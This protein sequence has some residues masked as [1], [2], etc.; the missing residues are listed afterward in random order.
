MIHSRG[1]INVVKF[2]RM[3]QVV[4]EPLPNDGDFCTPTSELPQ[5]ISALGGLNAPRNAGGGI[6]PQIAQ[7][8]PVVSTRAPEARQPLNDDGGGMNAVPPPSERQMERQTGV[9][10]ATQW[11]GFDPDNHTK[12]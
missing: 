11:D 6:G 4:F 3:D 2:T 1:G 12:K 9:V 10:S 5:M 7:D 8:L